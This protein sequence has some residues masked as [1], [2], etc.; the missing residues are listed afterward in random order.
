M[1]IFTHILMTFSMM[2]L[3]ISVQVKAQTVSLG[4]ETSAVPGNPVSIP[5][6]LANLGEIGAISLIIDF[7]PS[8]LSYTN[9]TL[10][11][12]GFGYTFGAAIVNESSPGHLIVSWYYIFGIVPVINGTVS[13][14]S[15]NFDYINGGTFLDFDEAVCE[16]ADYTNVQPIPGISYFN[17]TVS[18]PALRFDLKIFLE[19]AYNE[20]TNS[21][22]Q[23]LSSAGMIPLSQPFNPSL[24]YYG[25]PS[26]D[27]LYNGTEMVAS[28]P[29]NVVDWVLVQIRDASLVNQAGTSSIV[30]QKPCFVLTDGS[31]VDLDGSSVP[32]FYTSVDYGAFPVVYHRN[33]IGIM[34]ASAVVGSGGNYIYD[35]TTGANKVAGGASGYIELESGVWGLVAGDGNGDSMIDVDNDKTMVW[36]AQAGEKGYTAGDNNLNM[37][38]DNNDKNDFILKNSSYQ[39]GIPN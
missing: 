37:E 14:I 1:K 21:M 4:S 16:I 19:G 23:I 30:Y 26:P 24:P 7:N 10:D 8:V 15:L 39:T 25:N 11:N 18:E 3:I 6:T 13:F 34:S 32:A 38:V 31:I 36:S 29:L 22:N 27:W 28:I 35:F 12:T 5:I 9:F 2:F 17:G 20:N 33:H